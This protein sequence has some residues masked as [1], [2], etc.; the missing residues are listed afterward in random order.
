MIVNHAADES[1]F[2]TNT[3]V[4]GSAFGCKSAVQEIT[5]G[6]RNSSGADIDSSGAR[7]GC[8]EEVVIGE[9]GSTDIEYIAARLDYDGVGDEWAGRWELSNRD[10]KHCYRNSQNMN[11]FHKHVVTF[12]K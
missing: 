3:R 6:R 7:I 4:H 12:N 2:L 9:I 11:N 8:T 5:N 10:T 1:G